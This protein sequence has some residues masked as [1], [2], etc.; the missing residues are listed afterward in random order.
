[1]TDWTPPAPGPWQQDSAHSPNAWTPAMAELYPAGFN[2]GFTETFNRYGMLLD[3]L[4]MAQVNGFTYHQPQP[5]DM[6]R[7]MRVVKTLALLC[8]V[9]AIVAA[10]Q[11]GPALL[12]LFH[13]RIGFLNPE[14]GVLLSCETGRGKIFRRGTGTNRHRE[15]I[16]LAHATELP[17]STV[18]GGAYLRG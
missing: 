12:D 17:I 14:I 3:R 1:M 7:V 6:L 10:A 5:F 9:W 16:H 11:S 13:H 4:A 15:R 18:D 8:L 2:R